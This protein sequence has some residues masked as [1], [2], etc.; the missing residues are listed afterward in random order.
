MECSIAVVPGDGVGPEIVPEGVQA[1]E[2]VGKR[3]GHAFTFKKA[4]MGALA[5]EETGEALPVSTIDT[6]RSCDAILFGAVGLPKYEK[7]NLEKRPE[8]GYGLIRMRKILGSSQ[9]S[10]PCAS[11]PPWSRR[12]SSRE[13]LLKGST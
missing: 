9:T 10:A 13:R 5:F 2:A 7:P 4:L 6:C 11:S 1:L 12:A 3:F 8:L